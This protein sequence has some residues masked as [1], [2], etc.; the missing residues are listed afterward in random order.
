M[1]CSAFASLCDS[2]RYDMD[3]EKVNI[4]F[5]NRFVLLVFFSSCFEGVL[6]VT[7]VCSKKFSDELV[8][9]AC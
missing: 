6:F 1:R 3:L 4:Q 5:V 8:G 9:G 2:F 7:W